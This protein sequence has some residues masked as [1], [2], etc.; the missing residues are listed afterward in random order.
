MVFTIINCHKTYDM[1]DVL[2]YDIYMTFRF[3]IEMLQYIPCRHFVLT[4]KIY[5]TADIFSDLFYD[6]S[7]VMCISELGCCL[8]SLPESQCCYLYILFVSIIYISLDKE[9]NLSAQI[10]K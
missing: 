8:Y 1:T 9:N 10:R 5:M 6:I 2:G 3:G 4:Y 7:S